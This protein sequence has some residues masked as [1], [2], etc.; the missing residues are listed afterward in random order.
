MGY[1]IMFAYWVKFPYF[2]CS[3]AVLAVHLI[4]MAILFKI[5][6][7]QLSL[8]V[9]SV[10][11]WI[12]QFIL[13]IV[14]VFVNLVNYLGNIDEILVLVLGFFI[15]AISGIVVVLGGVRLYY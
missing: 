6:P 7:Y 4:Y 9:H 3:T 1:F 12:N 14:L 10:G 2:Y 13:L 11:M 15:V 8:N 5:S